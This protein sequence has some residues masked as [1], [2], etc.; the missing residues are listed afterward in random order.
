[1]ADENVPTHREM[2]RSTAAVAV[3]SST[4]AKS[5]IETAEL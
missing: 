5:S 1:M 3:R 2:D 4:K